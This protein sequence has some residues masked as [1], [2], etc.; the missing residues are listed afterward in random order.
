MVLFIL[1]K[2]QDALSGE[3]MGGHV[4]VIA[5][6]DAKLLPLYNKAK[7]LIIEQ[8]ISSHI[9]LEGLMKRIPIIIKAK[10]AMDV[11]ETSQVVTVDALRGIVYRG[12]TRTTTV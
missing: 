2:D 5:E 1:P 11:L 7:A 10:S 12:V 4:L 9:E 3:L 6:F 8:G